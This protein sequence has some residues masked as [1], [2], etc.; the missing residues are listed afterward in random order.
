MWVELVKVCNRLQALVLPALNV[1]SVLPLGSF[2]TSY[3]ITNFVASCNFHTQYTAA[4]S[5]RTFETESS[6]KLRCAHKEHVFTAVFLCLR[7]DSSGI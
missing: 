7:R 1:R 6:S 2:L 5:C 4:L 3:L